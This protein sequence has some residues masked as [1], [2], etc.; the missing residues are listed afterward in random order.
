MIRLTE[1]KLPLD[2]TPDDLNALVHTT[3]G[4]AASD[5]AQWQICKRSYDA[6]KAALLVV[7]IVDVAL[8]GADVE[9]VALSRHSTNRHIFAAPDMAY[10]LVAQA[11]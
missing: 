2:H 7:Y 8:H 9:A 4:V 10:R 6:R 1:L 5:I 3:L 11:P